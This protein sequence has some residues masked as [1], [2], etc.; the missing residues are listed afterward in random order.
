MAR[1][2]YLGLP[3]GGYVDPSHASGNTSVSSRS[4]SSRRSAEYDF[5]PFS[6]SDSP[7]FC[8]LKFVAKPRQWLKIFSK[9]R[10]R[11]SE[12]LMRAICSTTSSMCRVF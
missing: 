8:R 1:A 12:R 3:R 7:I 6:M 4:S 10:G 9:L 5:K 11:M 2:V